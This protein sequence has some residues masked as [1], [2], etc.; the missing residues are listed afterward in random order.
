MS[1]SLP[2]AGTTGCNGSGCFAELKLH[3][4]QEQEEGEMEVTI[5]KPDFLEKYGKRL[6][7][8]TVLE[9]VEQEYAG[10]E[11][12]TEQDIEI[13]HE[14]DYARVIIKTDSGS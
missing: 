13:Q 7:P 5:Y 3:E 6:T 10:D 8:S 12:I 14:N 1:V 2:C 11:N 4:Y 9:Y